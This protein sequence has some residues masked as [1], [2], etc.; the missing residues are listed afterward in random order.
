MLDFSILSNYKQEFLS[1]FAITLEVSLMALVGSFILGA[2]LAVMRLA[3]FKPLN[4]LS[5]IYVEFIRNTPILIQVFFFYFGLP[6]L[7]IQLTPFVS[8]TLGLTVYTG[9]FIAEVIRAGIQS[10]P[11]GQMEA[12]RASGLTYM[13]TMRY[14]IL[15]QAVKI[16][17]PALG[18]QFLNL[19]KNSAVLAVISGGDLMY[20]GDIVS[21]NTFVVFDVY[22]FVAMFYLLITIPLSIFVNLLEHRLAKTG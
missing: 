20:Q 15:P 9:A 22:I 2:I 10:V 14:I 13:Q 19:V 8:G 21:S 16:V 12:G 11:Q 1:G 18:N 3:P 4:V 6:A 17:I 5:R 7:G